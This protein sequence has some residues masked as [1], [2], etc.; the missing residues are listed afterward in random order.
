MSHYVIPAPAPEMY[1]QP[2]DT[3][4]VELRMGPLDTARVFTDSADALRK[5]R[6]FKLKA[7][8]PVKLVLI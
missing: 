6:A 7:P 8:V 1:L 2:D 4:G 5:A 3:G